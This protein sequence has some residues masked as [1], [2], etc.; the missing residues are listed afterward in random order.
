MSAVVVIDNEVKLRALGVGKLAV[1]S[2][3]HYL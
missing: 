3:W 2:L 1:Y